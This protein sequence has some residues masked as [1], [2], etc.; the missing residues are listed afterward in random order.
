MKI[1]FIPLYIVWVP[2]KYRE[3]FDYSIKKKIE[4]VGD[5]FHPDPLIARVIWN[6]FFNPVERKRSKN[7][8][9]KTID[10]MNL[11]KDGK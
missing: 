10:T 11:T 1:P 5:I 3:A 7:I 9:K 2:K 6:Y 4:K 8:I